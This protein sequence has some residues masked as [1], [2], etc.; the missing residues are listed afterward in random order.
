M[1][2]GA[3]AT[4][5]IIT[6]VK[7]DLRNG[8]PCSKPGGCLHYPDPA[9]PCSKTHTHFLLEKPG[10]RAPRHAGFPRPVINIAAIPRLGGNGFANTAQT[11]V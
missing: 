3:E 11:G 4:G 9:P 6:K 10:K 7:R 1:K 8:L 2:H 5:I